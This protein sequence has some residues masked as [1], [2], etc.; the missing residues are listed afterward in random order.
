MA[1]MA[2]GQVGGKETKTLTYNVSYSICKHQKIN[3]LNGMV[4]P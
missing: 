4:V 1:Q 2:L 3:C